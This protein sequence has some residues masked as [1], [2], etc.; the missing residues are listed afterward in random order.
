[1]V[2]ALLSKSEIHE[3]L[4]AMRGWWLQSGET[5]LIVKDYRFESEEEARDF[6]DKVGSIAGSLGKHPAIQIDGAQVLVAT[7]T[8]S[9]GGVTQKDFFLAGELEKI[10]SGPVAIA[11]KK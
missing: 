10:A 1:M 9:E 5:A 6:A 4:P 3:K 8:R 11:V 2:M 7:H